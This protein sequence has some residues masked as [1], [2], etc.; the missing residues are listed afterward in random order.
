MT[1]QRGAGKHTEDEE[2]EKYSN[3]EEESEQRSKFQ[4]FCAEVIGS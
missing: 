2:D 4:Q 1:W 3:D